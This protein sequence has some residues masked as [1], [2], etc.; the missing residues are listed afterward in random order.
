MAILKRLLGFPLL[1]TVV[2]LFWIFARQTGE[3][4][5]IRLGVL[6]GL[7]CFF[8]WLSGVFAKP[9]KPWLHF[10]TLW[11]VFILISTLSWKFLISPHIQVAAQKETE[12]VSFSQEK[13]D[14]LQSDGVA[15]WVNGTADWC[16][17]CKV[18]EK[19][20]FDNENVKKL[21]ENAKIVKM[22]IDYTNSNDE[23][24]KFFETYGRSGVPFDL[25]LTSKREAILMSEILTKDAV[26]EAL[27]RV[28]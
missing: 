27:E 28:Y 12:W 13:L 11:L 24:L 22:R 15:V 19:V 5:S 7:A 1:L 23:A 16:I 18:N 2:W 20:V 14:S 21:F 8:A 9:G 25:L 4:A 6:L 26:I 17:T 3:E 10:V